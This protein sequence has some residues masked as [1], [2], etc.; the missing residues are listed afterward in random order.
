MFRD[1]ERW[2]TI[3]LDQLDAVIEENAS[4]R[5]RAEKAEAERDELAKAID[6][7]EIENGITY[8]GNLWRFWASKAKDLAAKA[9]RAAALEATCERMAKALEH[10]LAE[11]GGYQIK[12]E[13]ERMALAALSEYRKEASE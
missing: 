7:I 5:S 10:C 12:G 6:S 13:T 4:L 2:K 1:D 8:E 3:F 9:D 11:H